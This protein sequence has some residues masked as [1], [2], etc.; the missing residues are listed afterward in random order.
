MWTLER[1]LEGLSGGEINPDLKTEVHYILGKFHAKRKGGKV[2]RERVLRH[3]REGLLLVEGRETLFPRMSGELHLLYARMLLRGRE[4]GVTTK[5][6]R[7]VNRAKVVLFAEG[8]VQLGFE[9]AVIVGDAFA[10]CE[11]EPLCEN[12]VRAYDGYEEAMG[13]VDMGKLNTGREWIRAGAMQIQVMLRYLAHKRIVAEGGG[14]WCRLN[15]FAKCRRNGDDVREFVGAAVA[16]RAEGFRGKVMRWMEGREGIEKEEEWKGKIESELHEC[17]GRAYLEKGREEGR[18]EDLRKGVS[19][20]KKA[21]NCCAWEEDFMGRR[22]AMLRELVEETEKR[23]QTMER[24]GGRGSGD[25]DESSEEDGSDC[26]G[27]KTIRT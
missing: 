12:L 9:G 13:M 22:Y 8:D 19:G 4:A 7:H 5:I 14:G 3:C 21:V 2:A 11:D 20:L 15:E 27:D 23:I 26:E 17:V 6:V 10:G 25:E 16:K 18:I 1:Q 24:E